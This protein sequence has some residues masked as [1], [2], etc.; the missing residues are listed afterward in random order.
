ME[1]YSTHRRNQ[2]RERQIQKKRAESTGGSHFMSDPNNTTQ[3][4]KEIITSTN[5]QDFDANDQRSPSLSPINYHY[6][7][8]GASQ[9]NA[10]A[11]Y[12]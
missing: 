8:E 2:E 9:L 5:L 12:Q 6:R 1:R 10:K 3:N 4:L 7:Q 11:Y